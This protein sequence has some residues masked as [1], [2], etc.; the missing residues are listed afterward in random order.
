M[1]SSRLMGLLD[2]GSARSLLCLSMENTQACFHTSGYRWNFRTPLKA[3]VRKVTTFRERFIR[4]LFGK[5]LG[6]GALP[7]FN[8]ATALET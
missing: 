8:S 6:P 7:T 1:V 4:A 2:D 5:P 3:F